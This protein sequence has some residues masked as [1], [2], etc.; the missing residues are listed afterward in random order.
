[1]RERIIRYKGKD[2]IV[3][4]GIDRC[5]HVAE[6]IRGLPKVFDVS[7]RPWI[8][9][10]AAEVNKLAD[11]ILRCPTGALHFRRIDDGSE[12][13]IPEKNIIKLVV[14]GPLYITGNIQLILDN[15]EIYHKDTRIALCR[16]GASENKP[17]CDNGHLAIDFKENGNVF[18]SK[19]ESEI[20]TGQLKVSISSN[21]SYVVKGPMEIRDCH[22]RICFKGIKTILCGCG[23]SKKKPFCDGSHN[24]LI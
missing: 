19:S 1:M 6:C 21:Q 12:E 14:D 20:K 24:Y 5:T 22:D 11:V 3:L 2:I 15:G 16:C 17:F 9:P 18:S 8:I 13:S 4:F 10:D 23:T 7:R